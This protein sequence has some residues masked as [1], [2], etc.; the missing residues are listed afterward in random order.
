[1]SYAVNAYART[2]QV[3]LT[4]R[5]A[6]AAVLMKAARQIQAV[7]D[8]WDNQAGGLSGALNFNQKLWTILATAATDPA[9]P[10]PVDLRQ[11][12]AGLSAF[13]FGR[14]IEAMT[15]PSPEKLDAL[16]SINQHLAAGLEGR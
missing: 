15:A 6:E 3:A 1:M 13:I 10:L 11:Q 5:E 7:R 14:M 16:I 8:D 9:S 2:A 12:V 4:P